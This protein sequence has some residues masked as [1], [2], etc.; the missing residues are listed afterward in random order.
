[1]LQTRVL[2]NG[3]GGSSP[4]AGAADPSS[5]VPESG[6]A[7]ISPSAVG[8][9]RA[10]PGVAVVAL[11]LA[12]T[13]Y[14]VERAAATS[15]WVSIAA[16]G[17]L[18]LLAARALRRWFGP[19][20]RAL[21]VAATTFSL[22][23]AVGSFVLWDNFVN[24]GLYYSTTYDD[25]FYYF[26]TKAI[27]AEGLGADVP[28]TLFEIVLAGYAVLLHPLKA[29]EPT[30]LLPFEWFLASVTGVLVFQLVQEIV[31]SRRLPIAWGLLTTLG[32]YAY[33]SVIPFLYRDMLVT[34]GFVGG[35]LSAWRGSRLACVAFLGV[36]LATR[37]AHGVLAA[38]IC[39]ALFLVGSLAFRR[40][41]FVWSAAFVLAC[42]AA[43][44]A[45]SA[46]SSGFMSSRAGEV[47]EGDVLSAAVE[48]QQT[49]NRTFAEEGTSVGARVMGLGPM[50]YPLRMV[51]GYFAPVVLRSP[52]Y[53]KEVNTLFLRGSMGEFTQVHGQF[54]FTYAEWFTTLLWPVTAPLLL[55]GIHR[56][57]RGTPRRRALVVTLGIAFAFIMVVS[58][59]ERHRIEILAF[60]PIFVAIAFEERWT[61][62]ERRAVGLLQAGVFIGIAALNAITFAR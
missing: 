15:M 17:I 44:F 43:F 28:R 52:E 55:L 14:F 47:G 57:A 11:S 21:T 16:S 30:D 2:M 8:R 42:G 1:M 12:T 32:Q 46:V 9:F 19:Q 50:G 24:T 53:D 51:T 62:L 3:S 56:M 33:L 13:L 6:S 40:R 7:S 41:P 37:A 58:M 54:L 60:N 10:A 36:A 45:A 22:C 31:P 38:F 27:A 59:Q 25:S 39:V 48:R 61:A 49:W 20:S 29:L 5:W 23:G 18:T 34:V 35:V 26:N 4:P